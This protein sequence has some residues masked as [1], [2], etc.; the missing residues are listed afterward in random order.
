MNI[1]DTKLFVNVKVDLGRETMGLMRF[2]HDCERQL[3]PHAGMAAT[4]E[5]LLLQSLLQPFARYGLDVPQ[6]P[7]H[8]LCKRKKSCGVTAGVGAN[9]V[10]L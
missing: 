2:R 7:G 4:L 8:I 10:M 1:G 6:T 5:P 3:F 9:S